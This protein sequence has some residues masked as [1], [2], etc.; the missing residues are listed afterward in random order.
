[1]RFDPNDV[2][3]CVRCKTVKHKSAFYKDHAREDC[4]SNWCKKCHL[5]EHHVFR[6]GNNKK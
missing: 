3:I 5:D 6:R 4:L 1:M 2:K